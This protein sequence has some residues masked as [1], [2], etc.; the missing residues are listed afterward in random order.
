MEE[1][2]ERRLDDVVDLLASPDLAIGAS[3]PLLERGDSVIQ[4]GGLDE[5][6]STLAGCTDDAL[7]S[8]T[9]H[10]GVA[11]PLLDS[12]ATLDTRRELLTVVGM[13]VRRSIAQS[14]PPNGT[15]LGPE[16]RLGLSVVSYKIISLMINVKHYFEN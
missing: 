16:R 4:I 14:V 7:P 5:A 12:L 2:A 15:P 1:L 3:H 6:V 13:V 8:A 10:L 9:H 11:G